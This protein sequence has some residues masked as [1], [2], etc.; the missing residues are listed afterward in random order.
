MT[1]GNSTGYLTHG[2]RCP[3]CKRWRNHHG[4]TY[5]SDVAR[6]GPRMYPAQEVRDHVAAL[7]A[8]GWTQAQI[9]RD[10]GHTSAWLWSILNNGHH[11]RDGVKRWVRRD[12]A[13]AILAVPPLLGDDAPDPVVVDRLL[14]GA[15]WRAIGANRAERI[16]A[17]EQMP[18]PGNADKRYGLRPGRDFTPRRVAS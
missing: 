12:I 14:A 5:R 10:L 8:S 4:N 17:A 11:T 13:A 15:S 9:A 1:H 7:V 6:N 2:C 3:E 18:D 16:A